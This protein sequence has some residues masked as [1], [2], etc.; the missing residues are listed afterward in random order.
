MPKPKKQFMRRRKPNTLLKR[1]RMLESSVKA[2]ETKKHN[3]AYGEAT[4]SAN[5]GGPLQLNNVINDL[6]KSTS[7]NGIDGTEYA[8]TGIAQKWFIH[9]QTAVDLIYRT[10]IIRSKEAISGAGDQLFLS[11]NGEGLNYQSAS[12]AQKIY[13]TLNH[14]KYD[15]IFEDMIKVGKSNASATS[16]YDNNQFIKGYKRFNN[17]KE[18]INIDGDPNDR[19]YLIAWVVDANLDDNACDIELSGMTTFYYKDN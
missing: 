10:C 7:A 15:I 19:Y 8:L 3:T 16:Q 12:E 5:P 11:L 2:E 18:S 1:V 4:V 14:K 13:L 6:V 9:N 17:K